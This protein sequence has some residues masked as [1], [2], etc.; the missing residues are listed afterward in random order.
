MNINKP[1]TN[2]ILS[3]LM[4]LSITMSGT[5]AIADSAQKDWKPTITVE[6]KEKIQDFIYYFIDSEKAEMLGDD[7]YSQGFPWRS[8]RAT[9]EALKTPEAAGWIIETLPNWVDGPDQ[10]TLNL[11]CRKA[12]ELATPKELQELIIILKDGKT[13]EN[14]REWGLLIL[15]KTSKEENLN[16]LKGNIEG[17]LASKDSKYNLEIAKAIAD[18]LQKKNKPENMEVLNSVIKALENNN[19]YEKEET[20]S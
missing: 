4:L 11:L 14:S 17:I 13:P 6:E 16:F 7:D 1:Q 18:S 3:T 8:F 9:V 5:N 10:E 20:K 2:V 19:A 12:T 15:E